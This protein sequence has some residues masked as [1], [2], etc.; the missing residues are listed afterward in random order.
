M[1]S[2]PS[3]RGGAVAGALAGMVMA[4]FMMVYMAASEQSVWTTPI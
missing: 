3:V 2:G 1:W 4:V